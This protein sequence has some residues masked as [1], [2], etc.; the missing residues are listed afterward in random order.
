MFEIKATPRQE[1]GRKTN[2]QR[3]AGQIPAVIYGHGV[4][5]EPLYVNAK[6][7]IKVYSEAGE[8]SLITLEV[9]GKNR[10]VLI[11]DVARDPLGEEFLHVDF[12][13]VKMDEK[14]KAEVPLNFI[15]ESLAVKAEA[16]VLVKNIKE[17]EIEALPK[18]LPH[19]ID[20]DISALE[21]FE[22]HIFVKDINVPGGVKIIADENEIVASVIP[23]RSEEELAALEEKVEEKVEEVK[24]VGEEE[25]AAEAA[26]AEPGSEEKKIEEKA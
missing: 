23:P 16:G 11:H 1:L 9:G 14:I 3:K 25:K 24:V 2:K 10:N 26:A 5:S 6:D 4:K 19:H 7:F 8:S 18:D 22:D 17:V 20:V 13:Q 21:N 15:G 12:Y